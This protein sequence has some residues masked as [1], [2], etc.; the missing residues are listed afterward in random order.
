[1]TYGRV[2]RLP[3]IVGLMALLP[4]V[5]AGGGGDDVER[6]ATCRAGR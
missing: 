3:A 1:M 2:G 6:R 4:T 5:A